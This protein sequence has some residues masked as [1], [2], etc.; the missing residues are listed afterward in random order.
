V[1][2]KSAKC[3]LAALNDIARKM[4]FPILGVDSDNGSES[5]Q[6][7]TCSNGAKGAR[8]LHPRT[9]R[10][11]RTTAVT[12][13]RRTGQWSAHRRLHRYDTAAELLLPTRSGNCSPSDQTTP[14]AAELISKVRKGAKYPRST[15]AATRFT[16]RSIT[17]HE[18]ERIVALTRPTP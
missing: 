9:G 5:S 1:P 12:S 17:P 7:T 4:P 10:A 8:S 16:A 6:R 18:R 3:V 14:T 2:D 11:T 15:K 13:S